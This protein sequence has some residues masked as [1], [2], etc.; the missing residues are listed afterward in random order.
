M[1]PPET[2]ASAAP[3]R[4]VVSLAA[5]RRNLDVVRQR[6]APGMELIAC[7][8]ANAYGHGVLP[9]SACLQAAGVRWLP[10]LDP[11]RKVAQREKTTQ[12]AQ[13]LRE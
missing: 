11:F 5:L 12:L 9:V 8:K 1:A 6:L 3:L 4:A 10:Q 13:Q 7:V 2:S